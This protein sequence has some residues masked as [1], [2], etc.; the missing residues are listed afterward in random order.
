MPPMPF[1]AGLALAACLL[2]F[3]LAWLGVRVTLAYA[4]RRGLLDLPG[5]RRSHVVPTPRGGGLGLL[6]GTL[7]LAAWA[8]LA[9]APPESA[10][11]VTAI[12]GAC[13]LVMLVGW[14]DDHGELRASIRLLAHLAAAAL[15]SWAVLH[16]LGFWPWPKTLALGGALALAM[17]WSINAHNFMDGID[18]LLGLQAAFC[19]TAFGLLALAGGQG[20]HALAAWCLAAGCLAFLVFNLPPARIFMGDVGS[21]TLGLLVAVCAALL[22][23]RAPATFWP[24]LMLCSA[25]VTDATLTLLWRMQAG[26]RWYTAHREHLYQWLVRRG[27]SHLKAGMGYMLWN[28][29]LA[30]PAAWWATAEPHLAAALALALYALA[31][32]L[33][34]GT[35][36][37]C[38]HAARQGRA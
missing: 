35:R 18:G 19:F 25:F 34:I 27:A 12:L 5:R 31:T 4:R 1:A 30:A 38:L 32:V 2:A 17:A 7:P 9:W 22:W 20:G 21:G 6:L 26:R 13:A 15:A 28:L 24:L 37:A 14:I 36:S 23:R 33:W 16:G 8:W 3:V 29:L 10:A 11:T